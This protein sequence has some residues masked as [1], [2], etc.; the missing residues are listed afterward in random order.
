MSA[1]LPL[2]RLGVSRLH[3]VC[4]VLSRVVS[5]VR[6]L[7]PLVGRTPWSVRSCVRERSETNC[8]ACGYRVQGQMQ[9]PPGNYSNRPGN[10]SNRL[11]NDTNRP[12]NDTT[13]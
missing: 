1:S 12:G 10:V 5:V 9:F 13:R 11:G 3:A 4:D 2:K 6:W 8:R 7:T